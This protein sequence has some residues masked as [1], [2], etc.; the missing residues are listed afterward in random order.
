MEYLGERALLVVKD[1][2][3]VMCDPKS[4]TWRGR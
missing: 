1:D 4:H 3:L 2:V